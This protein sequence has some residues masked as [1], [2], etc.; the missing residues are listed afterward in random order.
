MP[1]LTGVWRLLSGNS[2]TSSPRLAPSASPQQTT[3][4]TEPIPNILQASPYLRSAPLASS[5]AISARARCTPCASVFTAS[6]ASRRRTT[7]CWVCCR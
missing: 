6:M 7:T 5:T 2:S 1:S 3:R 4:E